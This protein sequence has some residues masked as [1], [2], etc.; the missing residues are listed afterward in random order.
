MSS[1]E[2]I[3][4]TDAMDVAVSSPPV[5]DMEKVKLLASEEMTRYS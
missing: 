3:S 5:S 4:A 2:A 1:T